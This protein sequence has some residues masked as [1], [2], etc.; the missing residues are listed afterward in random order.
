MSATV[1][2]HPMPTAARTAWKSMSLPETGRLGGPVWPQNLMGA[3]GCSGGG[4]IPPPLTHYR[5]LSGGSRAG[6]GFVLDT[7][8]GIKT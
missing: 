6:A 2:G 5:R 8:P 1:K 7:K 4:D 3:G